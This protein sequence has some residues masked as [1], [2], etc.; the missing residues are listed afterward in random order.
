MDA[1]DV[2]SVAY[3]AHLH[4]YVAFYAKPMENQILLR[5]APAPEG[6]WSEPRVA[7]ATRK[8]ARLWVYDGL[9]HPEF[10]RE[11]GR[12]QYLT[13]SLTTEGGSEVRLVEVELSR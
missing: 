4:A 5:T 11:S 3:N 12:I 8:P 13:Y 9:A 2:L 10:E 7:F 6:P 1:N